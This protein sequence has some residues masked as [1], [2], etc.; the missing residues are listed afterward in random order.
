MQ[1]AIGS[2]HAGFEYKE[3][4]K[5]YL[6]ELGHTVHDFGTHSASP[7][8]YPL[9]IR[10]V[11]EAVALGEFDRG[12]VLGGSGNG[13]AIVANR[14]RGIRCALC[15][16]L[17]TARWAREHNNANL[18]SMGQRLLSFDEARAIVDV[19]LETEFAGGR[20]ARRIRMIDRNMHSDAEPATNGIVL[21][22]TDSFTET[23]F[24]CNSC[25]EEFLIPIDIT[26]GLEQTL[27]EEC[28]VCCY[29][30]IILISI[31]DDGSVTV[32]GDLHIT[33]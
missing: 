11:A 19:W 20:H 29:E 16:N 10:P 12:I 21:Q 27:L 4:L 22:R 24:V 14:V 17:K 31:G 30:N 7:V 28:P 18:L 25:R 6:M 13:E 33:G 1:I 32:K 23:R 9:F 5:L 8:D 2:D 15:W 3:G 26:E